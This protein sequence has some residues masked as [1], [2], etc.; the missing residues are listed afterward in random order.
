MPA[1][2][3]LHFPRIRPVKVCL[4]HPVQLDMQ[5]LGLMDLAVPVLPQLPA[6]LVLHLETYTWR[7]LSRRT[8]DETKISHERQALTVLV[9]L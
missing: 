7:L 8:W 4:G 2:H 6:V 5:V 1:R 3:R 9:S